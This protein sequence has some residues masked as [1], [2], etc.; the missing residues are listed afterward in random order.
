MVTAP[1]ENADRAPYSGIVERPKI[2]WPNGA[3]VALWVVPNIEH[4][5]YQPL[6]SRLR[7]P[8]PRT[9]HPDVLGYGIRDYGNRVGMW[10]L[11]EVMDAHGIRGTVSL[12]ISN[13][14]HYPEI[15]EACEARNWAYMSHGMYN[16]RYHW[17]Y[18]EDE[19][20]AAIAEA[21]DLY[22][23]LTGKH[24]RGWFTPAASFTLNTPDLVAEAG[25]T[26]YCDWYHDD[27][28]FPMRTRSGAPLITIPYTM[29]LNDSI[30]YR[31]Q[32]EGA[33]FDRM[34]RDA[35]DRLYIEGAEHPR[36]LCLAIHPFI[37]G[38]PHR[39]GHLDRALKYIMSHEGV[40][41]ATG[42]EI[43]D[44]YIEHHLDDVKQHLGWEGQDA[45][46]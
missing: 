15:F 41:A 36:V 13:F 6:P 24:L 16:S 21:A 45:T 23:Q 30:L 19:E 35:F 26:Y 2:T 33:D 38:Q 32:Y 20:R 11:F 12:N 14:V 22:R 39:I 28:P 37:L 27:Q 34:V 1:F 25:I 4:Y 29:D 44:W 40:W 8:W 42:E 18:E 46:R 9:P 7:D 31:Q 5:E 10:R 3:R 17:G 43:A